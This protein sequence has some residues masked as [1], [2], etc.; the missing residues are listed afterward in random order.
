M[1]IG[2]LALQGGFSRHMDMLRI[3][4]ACPREVRNPSDLISCDGLIIPGG[5]STAIKKQIMFS[6]MEAP[7]KEF[8]LQKPVFGTCAGLI[9]L[10][11]Y[12]FLN[13]QLERNAYGRQ[14]ESFSQ[15]L[16]VKFPA[17]RKKSF[18]GIFIRAP[19]II[20][21][22]PELQ[23]YSSYDNSPVLVQQG[24]ILGASFHPELSEDPSI[25]EY[26]VN[27]VS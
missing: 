3:L 2:V 24:H 17:K 20:S 18:K 7:L 1:A 5:E 23:V 15:T 26:F 12:G 22:S 14:F 25:H 21:H 16:E 8:C 11:H 10:S 4:G 6:G 27:N 19:R 9:L 13:L